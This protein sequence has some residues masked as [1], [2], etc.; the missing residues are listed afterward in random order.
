MLKVLRQFRSPDFSRELAQHYP[1]WFPACLLLP[2][3]IFISWGLNC[4][5]VTG[6][7][8]CSNSSATC[9]YLQMLICVCR[10]LW[11]DVGARPARAPCSHLPRQPGM[12]GCSHSLWATPKHRWCYWGFFKGYAKR[13]LF[14]NQTVSAATSASLIFVHVLQRFLSQ[15]QHWRTATDESPLKKEPS[16]SDTTLPWELAFSRWLLYIPRHHF[17]VR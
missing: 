11:R 9:E 16:F 5:R 13:M 17:G 15:S 6:S 7:R 8:C 14:G 3:R 4:E 1:Q 10:V 2:R 12:P